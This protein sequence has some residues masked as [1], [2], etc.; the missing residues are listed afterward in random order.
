MDTVKVGK[1]IAFLRNY[2]GLT[3]KNLAEYLGVTDK[4][5]S[6]WERGLGAPDISLLSRLAIILDT[7]IESILE[8]NITHLGLKWRGILNL[9]YAEGINAETHIF[10]K[11]TVCYQLTFFALAGIKN[12]C[13]RGEK[14]NVGCAEKLIGSGS[15]YG[16]DINYSQVD[17]FDLKNLIEGEISENLSDGFGVMLINGLDFLYGKDVTKNFRRIMYDGRFPVNLVNLKEK[18]TSI[19][20]F[21]DTFETKDLLKKHDFEIK[22]QIMERGIIT[23]PIKNDY[24]ILDAANIMRIIQERQGEKVADL[25]EIAGRRNLVQAQKN[26]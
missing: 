24:D 2:Y 26:Q 23:F 20:F 6:R 7:D 13:I 16:L 10:D 3:Q 5:V 18:P 8:G 14:T 17:S 11:K 9:E 21:P 25:S 12:I 15:E 4:A 22:N 1:S 19:Y